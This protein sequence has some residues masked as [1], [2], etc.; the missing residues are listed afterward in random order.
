MSRYL[1]AT[2]ALL[3]ATSGVADAVTTLEF[4][5]YES[6]TTSYELVLVL[7]GISSKVPL[8]NVLPSGSA[9]IEVLD[10]LGADINVSYELHDENLIFEGT[11][12]LLEVPWRME[13]VSMSYMADS[14]AFVGPGNF[15][16]GTVLNSLSMTATGVFEINGTFTDV[17]LGTTMPGGGAFTTFASIDGVVIEG[18]PN[19]GPSNPAACVGT[20]NAAGLFNAD[21]TDFIADRQKQPPQ[22]DRQCGRRGDAQN[23][24]VGHC[25]NQPAKSHKAG[26]DAP[27]PGRIVEQRPR[28]PNKVGRRGR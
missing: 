15:I 27:R 26:Y 18:G 19:C 8:N 2:A 3:L 1:A 6:S 25:G 24:F 22:G 14:E 17:E 9:T 5:F 28:L 21:G 16:D 7:D 10:D 11:I 13:I 20:P 23:W 4:P 12:G